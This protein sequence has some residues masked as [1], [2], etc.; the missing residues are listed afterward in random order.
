MDRE[1]FSHIDQWF[2]D[3]AAHAEQSG[4]PMPPEAW[5]AMEA[6]L[7]Q[8]EKKRRMAGFW[9]W[10]SGLSLLGIVWLLLN[11]QGGKPTAAKQMANAH[12]V[13]QVEG[14]GNKME[15][16]H[17]ATAPD[18]LFSLP[19]VQTIK[20]AAL[21]R[22][23]SGA[24][25]THVDAA[26]PSTNTNSGTGSNAAS[27]NTAPPTTY[28]S[29]GK[30]GWKAVP[31]SYTPSHS[32]LQ[33][34][35]AFT[36]VSFPLAQAGPQPPATK[37]LLQPQLTATGASLQKKQDQPD[38]RKK[39]KWYLN[40]TTGLERSFV[41]GNKPGETAFGGSLGFGYKL[42]R[43]WFIQTGLAYYPKKYEARGSDYH[44]PDGSYWN[45][46][47]VKLNTV[48][49][50]CRVLEWLVQARYDFIQR[51][52]ISVY[53]TTGLISSQMKKET[54]DYS[55][56]KNG[57]D[58]YYDHTYQTGKFRFANA[59][60]VGVGLEKKI[61]PALSLQLNGYFN[62]PVAGVGEGRVQLGALGISAGLRYQLPF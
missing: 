16:I 46:P 47:D 57:N 42:S 62:V 33:G 31:T 14:N 36:L 21:P 54:Y 13:N 1:Q 55:Y 34:W 40:G 12:S 26:A 4:M 28:G 49:A 15:E 5:P 50:D 38:L 7:D 27:T 23:R 41:T 25:P 32:E 61:L 24:K 22:E 59:V 10:F 18:G 29:I 6:L 8:K 44:T 43:R 45:Q 11:L 37:T 56:T 20:P 17:S 39:G 60:Q 2:R 51:K 3:A 53:G 19:S 30:D 9:W 35:E 48:E 52:K 58:Y